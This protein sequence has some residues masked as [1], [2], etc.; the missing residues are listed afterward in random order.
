MPRSLPKGDTKAPE[1][2]RAAAEALE[3][4]D[5]GSCCWFCR[6]SFGA[7][8]A[9]LRPTPTAPGPMPLGV[10][11]PIEGLAKDAGLMADIQIL[12]LYILKRSVTR[13]LKLM[14]ESAK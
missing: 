10:C 3:N 7:F 4:A 2:G 13:E 1:K 11:S 8:P 6:R 9:L 14:Y 12:V 5:C